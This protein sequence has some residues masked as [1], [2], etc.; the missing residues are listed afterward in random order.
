M[1]NK[2]QLQ[3]RWNELKVRLQDHWSQLSDGDLQRPR[4]T[5]DELVDVIQS[6][7]GAS[8]R[9]IEHYISQLVEEDPTMSQR[10]A[11]NA[12]EYTD[13]AQQYAEEA[14][15]EAARYAREG[16]QR[17]AHMSSDLSR[18]LAHTVRE[19]PTESLAVA[20]GVGVVAGALLLFGRRGR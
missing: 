11:E 13:S 9:E 16:Y 20:F 2:Q 10:V 18:K 6:K 4:G 19:R 7:T 15:R 3:D 14:A 5:S 1:L 8:R 12:Q 17:A